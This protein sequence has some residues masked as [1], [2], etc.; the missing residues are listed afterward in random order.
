MKGKA[1]YQLKAIF[2]VEDTPVM[3]K[4]IKFQAYEPFLCLVVIEVFE[5]P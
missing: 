3:I 4:I 2:G 1:A 5:D